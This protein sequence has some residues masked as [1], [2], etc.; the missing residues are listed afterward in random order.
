MNNVSNNNIAEAVYLITKDKTFPEQSLI[1]KKIID[2]L[3]KRRL[4]SQVP[5]ILARL[6]KT[7]NDRNGMVVAKIWSAK[8][9]DEKTNKKLTQVLIKRYSAKKIDF[10]ENLD[11]KL[12]GGL[13]IEV[14]DEV[15]DLTIKNKIKKLQE[16][17]TRPA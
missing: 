15:I 11:E 13:K 2:F 17:L 3:I 7:I 8:K 14:N 10:V 6:N 1:S 12:L 5:D 9:I 16:Y 4:L